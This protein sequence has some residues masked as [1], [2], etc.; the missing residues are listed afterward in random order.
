MHRSRVIVILI[1]VF[2]MTAAS[3]QEG[4]PEAARKFLQ[5]SE[6]PMPA[7]VA[8]RRLEATAQRFAGSGW[9]RVRV[10]LVP[11][12]SMTW[13][14]LDEGGSDYI[15][16]KV[17]LAMLEGEAETVEKN[18]VTRSGVA[19]PNYRFSRAATSESIAV[20]P[21]LE[22]FRIIPKRADMMLVDGTAWVAA[23]DGDLVQVDG[24]LAKSPSFWMKTVDVV[25]RYARIEGVRVP[26]STESTADVR[27][28]GRTVLRMTYAYEIING[29]PTSDAVAHR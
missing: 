21:G 4:V 27:F 29:Q 19:E 12:V 23:A 8:V 20:P 17:L 11:G 16:D 22:R 7:S 10:T 9:M 26:I 5:R 1:F 24:R 6:E 2:V 28:A 15:R 3:A 14:V 18:L 25:R 13:T